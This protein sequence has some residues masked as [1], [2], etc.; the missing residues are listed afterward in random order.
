M[1]TTLN[2]FTVLIV[3]MFSIPLVGFAEAGAK[4]DL[5][6]TAYGKAKVEI[7]LN[8]RKASGKT[9]DLA[10]GKPDPYIIVNGQSFRTER[11]EDQLSCTFYVPSASHM[12]IEV[13][14][15]DFEHDDFAGSTACRR[16]YL[17][18]TRSAQ[19]KVY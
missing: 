6:P 17:C 8:G 1:K 2:K 4:A 15:A 9:W 10:W 18:H 16:G 19:V 14:D 5:E 7:V 12:N 11:C 13:W 3:T